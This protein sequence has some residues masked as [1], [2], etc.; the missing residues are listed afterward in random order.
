MK[1]FESLLAAYLVA[2]AVFFIFEIRIARSV[3]RL[4]EELEHLK[5]TLEN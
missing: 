3:A 2:W 5:E 4:R 1:N